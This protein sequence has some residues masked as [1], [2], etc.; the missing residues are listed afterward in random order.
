M[1][2]D[3]I[4]YQ[5]G[6]V[7]LNEEAI[8]SA[9]VCQKRL[10]GHAD[11][12]YG[13]ATR[14]CWSGAVTDEMRQWEPESAAPEAAVL[15]S[16]QV[17]CRLLELAPGVMS[18]VNGVPVKRLPCDGIWF[19]VGICEVDGSFRPMQ[20]LRLVDAISRCKSGH[21][22]TLKARWSERAHRRMQVQHGIDNG[23]TIPYEDTE[24]WRNAAAVR[25]TIADLSDGENPEWQ[26]VL[27]KWMARTAEV[28]QHQPFDFAAE[29]DVAGLAVDAFDAYAQTL[30]R[31]L[32]GPEPARHAPKR[33][34]VSTRL[35]NQLQLAF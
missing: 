23:W 35:E 27:G 18:Q 15:T 9:S 11:D 34:R 14:T 7:R 1:T 24:E 33:R 10:A 2:S 28:W 6:A 20:M 19:D 12:G 16:E 22:P 31:T 17:R 4:E 30:A 13:L 8:L 32:H 29:A 5:H 21:Y 26:R 3:V 25:C